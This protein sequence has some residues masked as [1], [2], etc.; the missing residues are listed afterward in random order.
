M[1]GEVEVAEAE[2]RGDTGVLDDCV[3]RRELVA[4]PEALVFPAPAPLGGDP[5]RSGQIRRPS[6]VTS[7]ATFPITVTS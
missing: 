2:P 4:D 1:G 6:I 3:V 5:S 7:S